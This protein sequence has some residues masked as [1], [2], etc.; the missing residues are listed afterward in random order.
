MKIPAIKRRTLPV[1]SSAVETRAQEW[2]C[3]CETMGGRCE[4]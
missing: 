4:S 3:L 2:H 1:G